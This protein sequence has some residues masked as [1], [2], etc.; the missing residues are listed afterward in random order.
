MTTIATQRIDVT[1]YRLRLARPVSPGE[2]TLLRGYFGDVFADEVLLHHHRPDGSLNYDY[3]RVQ[4]KVI[5]R[6]A[7]LIGIAEGGVVVERLWKEANHT[8]LGGEELPILEGTLRRR[9]EPFGETVEPVEYR[10]LTPW[11]GLNQENHP[12]YLGAESDAERQD[13]LGRVLVGNCLSLA[14]SFGQ[15]VHCR[16]AA[17]TPGLRSRNSRLKGVPMIGFLGTFRINFLIP[18]WLGI[19]KSVSRGFGTVEPAACGKED[20][21]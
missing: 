11:L 6:T 5:D 4:F 15:H 18:A 7:R 8:R 12:K 13:L 1:E 3:P 16:L 17:E 10:F 19:G 9:A 14:K 21:C 20:P 2:A